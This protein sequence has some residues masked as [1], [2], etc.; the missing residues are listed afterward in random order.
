[1]ISCL[2]VMNSEGIKG[3]DPNIDLEYMERER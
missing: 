1:M 2:F 3:N